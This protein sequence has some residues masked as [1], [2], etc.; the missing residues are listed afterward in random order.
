MPTIELKESGLSFPSGKLLCIG[1]NYAMHAAEMGSD[2]PSEPMVFLKPSSALTTSGQ[3]IVLPSRSKSVHHEIELVVLIGTRIKNVSRVEAAQ[4]VVGYAVGLDMTARDLQSEAKRNGTPWSIAKGFDTFAPLG[5]MV[6]CANVADPQ[7]LDLRLTVN[8][9]V[10]QAG[11]TANMIFSV[12]DL[13]AFL[14]SIFTLEPGD[15]I[16][17]GTPEGVGEVNAGDI[18]VAEIG[19]FPALTVDVREE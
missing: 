14:S 18:L 5:E 8:G 15:L 6:A 12:V 9:V 3:S 1:R 11:S 19:G 13:V 17:T 10:R 7:N 16:Y 4:S 2:V